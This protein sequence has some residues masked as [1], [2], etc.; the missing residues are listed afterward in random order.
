MA[1]VRSVKGKKTVRDFSKAVI[2]QGGYIE[3][4]GRHSKF[5]SPQGGEVPFPSHSGDMAT[6]TAY[7]IIK[8]LLAIGFISIT[9]YISIGIMECI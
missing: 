8:M 9:V 5:V 1:K 2:S 3:N 7:K 6:G 4:G